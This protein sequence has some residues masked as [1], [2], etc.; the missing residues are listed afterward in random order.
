[1]EDADMH[2]QETSGKRPEPEPETEEP[3]QPAPPVIHT[4]E[5]VKKAE[6]AALNVHAK[7]HQQS[8]PIRGY[9]ESTVVPTMLAGMAAVVKER[10]ENPVEYLAYYLLTHNPKKSSNPIPVA[11]QSMFEN[12]PS[13]PGAPTWLKPSSAE[14]PASQEAAGTGAAPASS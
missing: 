4:P 11:A 13:T 5:A 12:D 14:E 3:A 2:D 6:Q 9:L 8:A 10:P 1:M 7:I